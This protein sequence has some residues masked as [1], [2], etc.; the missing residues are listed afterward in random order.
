MDV[1]SYQELESL[2]KIAE[3]QGLISWRQAERVRKGKS[4]WVHGQ[5]MS[6]LQLE[7]LVS[8]L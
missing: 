8:A 5:N 2:A 1:T 3:Q 7:R 4:V 6:I